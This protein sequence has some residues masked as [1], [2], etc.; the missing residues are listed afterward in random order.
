[1]MTNRLSFSNRE[2]FEEFL[3]SEKDKMYSI[4]WESI[5]STFKRG[6]NSA[7]IV[8]IYLEEEGTY[9]DMI[10]DE[11]DWIKSLNLA[12]NYYIS[13]EE[14]EKCAKLKKLIEEIQNSL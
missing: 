5:N 7:Y 14:Y 13:I 6:E 3:E 12:L 9:I 8:E 1:M 10:S 11:E 2:E 4:I